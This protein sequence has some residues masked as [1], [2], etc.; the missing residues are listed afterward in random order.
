MKKK[1]SGLLMAIPF[2]TFAQSGY[3]PGYVVTNQGDTLKGHIEHKERNINPSKFNFKP[4]A[5]GQAQE[6]ALD[7]ALAYGIDDVEAYERHLVSISQGKEQLSELSVGIDTTSKTDMVFLKVLQKGKNMSLYAFQDLIKKRFYIL[8]YDKT[9]PEELIRSK[10]LSRANNSTAMVDN[11]YLRQFSLIESN[12]YTTTNPH[13]FKDL[14]YL[15]SDLLKFVST[16]N[17]Q[18][19]KSAGSSVR[20]FVGAALNMSKANYIAEH[21]LAGKSARSKTSYLPMVKVGV[22]L[23]ANPAT[24]K[25][26]YRLELGLLSSNYDISNEIREQTTVGTTL[27]TYSH[28][29]NELTAQLTP[30]IIY[31]LY[32]T[33]RLAYYVSGGVSLN[34]S[35]YS[36][37]VVKNVFVNTSGVESV[38]MGEEPVKFE[39]FY[40]SP[41]LSTGFVLNHKW[42]LAASYV[43]KSGITNYAYYNIEV[44]RINVGVNFLFGK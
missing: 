44:Q 33:D 36:K 10:Y 27:N 3:K 15:E 43:F 12:L 7:D 9:T 20:L 32:H 26:V 39:K 23:F 41:R 19:V 21:P 34:F 18:E 1:L 24:K 13:Q 17:G 22:D 42:E 14:R 29:F 25:L 6:Y 5:G 37:S 31:N 35:G 30:Q 28:T 16:M 2:L 8:P 38:R 11:K 40:I 4:S